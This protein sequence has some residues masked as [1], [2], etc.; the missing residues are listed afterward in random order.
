MPQLV[1]HAESGSACVDVAGRLGLNVGGNRLHAGGPILASHSNGAWHIGNMPIVRITCDG[2]IQLE[3]QTHNG[4]RLFGPFT[5]LVIGAE[6]IWTA[7]GPFARYN[8]VTK[9]WLLHMKDGGEAVVA[10]SVLNLVPV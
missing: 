5:S 7:E 6:T 8:P 4:G 3:L 10:A 9:S 2:P 1:F